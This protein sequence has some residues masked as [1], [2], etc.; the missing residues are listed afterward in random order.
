MTSP[1][2]SRGPSASRRSRPGGPGGSRRGAR[3]KIGALPPP[4]WSGFGSPR[5]KAFTLIELLVVLI[6]I[7]ILA[8]ISLGGISVIRATIIRAQNQHLMATIKV[9]LSEA[10]IE[11]SPVVHP[12]AATAAHPDVFGNGTAV[13]RAMFY[14][15]GT[16]LATSGEAL[17]VDDLSWLD[18]STERALMPDDVFAGYRSAGDAPPFFGLE[19]RML[20][21]VGVSAVWI[22]SYRA[23]PGDE[24]I[25]FEAGKLQTPYDA[26]VYDDREFLQETY[27]AQGETLEGRSATAMDRALGSV[28]AELSKLQALRE[29]ASPDKS[30]WLQETYTITTQIDPSYPSY[31]SDVTRDIDVVGPEEGGYDSM[32]RIW[33]STEAPATSDDWKPG[34]VYDADASQWRRYQPRGVS[35]VDGYDGEILIWRARSG[36][37]MVSSPGPDGAFLVEPGAN[38]VIDTDPATFDGTQATLGGDDLLAINDNQGTVED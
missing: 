6:I 22:D 36:G 4:V 12:L 28:M 8:G 1:L 7:A 2:P 3:E 13:T 37:I 16:P 30:S 9:G 35:L 38:G 17:R 33:Y 29:S 25:Y 23:L 10:E 15:G 31:T 26:T 27:L 11:F 5:V 21:A 32:H 34:F 14:R 20:T 24:S 19:R 18:G